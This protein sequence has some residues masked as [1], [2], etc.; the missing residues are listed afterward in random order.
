M[1]P[2]RRLAIE[3]LRKR[4]LTRGNILAKV[5]ELFPKFEIKNLQDPRIV[6]TGRLRTTV[7]IGEF[8]DPKTNL[9]RLVLGDANQLTF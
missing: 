9:G 4:T 2:R 1:R 3:N 7:R 8:L 6:G 5:L